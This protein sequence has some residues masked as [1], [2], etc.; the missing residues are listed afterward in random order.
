VI[1]IDQI[2]KMWAA[3][4]PGPWRALRDGNQRIGSGLVGTS[5]IPELERPYNR[6]AARPEDP[7]MVRFR[8]E[9]A[10]A[11]AAAPEHIAWLVARVRELG[12]NVRTLRAALY[13]EEF[14]F[15]DD[16]ED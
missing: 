10:I 9:D 11:I 2:E 3:A 16:P 15:C 6:Y 8:D 13:R 4:T 1:D 14:H 5:R 12:A 7:H